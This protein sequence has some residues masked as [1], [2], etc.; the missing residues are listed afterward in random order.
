M[1]HFCQKYL[2]SP[3]KPALRCDHFLEGWGPLLTQKSYFSAKTGCSDMFSWSRHAGGWHRAGGHPR[4]RAGDPLWTVAR[5]A[6]DGCQAGPDSFLFCQLGRLK[7][8]FQKGFLALGM[9]SWPLRFP[10]WNV[11]TKSILHPANGH[12]AHGNIDHFLT[13]F[14]HFCWKTFEK[15]RGFVRIGQKKCKKWSF[16]DP[17]GSKNVRLFGQK[18]ENDHFHE[19]WCHFCSGGPESEPFFA[20]NWDFWEWVRIGDILVKKGGF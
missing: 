13:L 11:K 10:L 2:K 12:L 9:T 7:Q 19:K 3:L 1:T 17:G 5:W 16:S 15:R 4:G 14:D 18:S 20:W 8:W 6:M